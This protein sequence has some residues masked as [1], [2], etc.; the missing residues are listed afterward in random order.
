MKGR[1]V[2]SLNTKPD[3][4]AHT[5]AEET[6]FFDS[7]MKRKNNENVNTAISNIPINSLR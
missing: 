6:K 3:T 5:K 7:N 1:V 4:V 2:H